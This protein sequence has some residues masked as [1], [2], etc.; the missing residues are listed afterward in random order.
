M[1]SKFIS[2]AVSRDLSHVLT[3]GSLFAQVSGLVSQNGGLLYTNDISTMYQDSAGTTPVTAVDDHVALWQDQ[4]NSND[5]SQSTAG[6]RPLLKQAG[7]KYYL[8]FDGIDDN[9]SALT[10]VTLG[11]PNTISIAF[12]M[13]T[14]TGSRPFV[15]GTSPNRHN[16]TIDGSNRPLIF[17]GGSLVDSTTSVATGTVY[18]MTGIY[19]GASSAIRIDGV[20][21]A[22]GGAGAESLSQLILGGNGSAFSEV[23][24]YGMAIIN[25]RLSE[26]ELSVVESYL[27]SIS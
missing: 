9:L 3:G 22:T 21:T 1:P 6:N 17:A 14:A 25:A 19:D 12:S 16:M 5:A 24:I 11:Q 26:S 10:A 4:G 27:T 20:E 18:V 15:A 7:D 23:H 8:H 2:R 13:T